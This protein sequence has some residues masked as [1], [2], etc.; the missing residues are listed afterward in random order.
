MVVKHKV[1]LPRLKVSFSLP[2]SIQLVNQLF[3]IS[4]VS[5]KLPRF[6]F[7]GDVSN[8]LPRFPE[9]FVRPWSAGSA[10]TE[11]APESRNKLER[12]DRKVFN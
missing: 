2:L 5:I 3:N 1:I 10:R 9:K 4:S 7:S 8:R 6:T 11:A 12:F